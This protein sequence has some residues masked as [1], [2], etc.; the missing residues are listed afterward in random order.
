L[1]AHF[2]AQGATHWRA[3]PTPYRDVTSPAVADFA[4]E[5]RAE[6]DFH[7]F[8]QFLSGKSAAAAQGAARHAGMKIGMISDIATGVDPS[9]SDCWGAPDDVLPG[10]SIGAPPDY[11]NAE[12]QGWG[13]TALSPR[14]LR[15]RGFD[16]FTAML[17]A[18]MAHAG[19]VRIDHVMSMM[20]LWVIPD[21]AKPLEGAYLRYPVEDLFRLTLLESYLH[22]AIVIGE[23][24][25]TVPHGFRDVLS[26][27]GLAGMQVLWFEREGG[28]F[29]PRAR[30]RRES[31][32]MTTTHDLPTLA[33]WWRGTDIGWRSQ[34][35]KNFD[36]E[37]ETR[38][39]ENDRRTL[40]WTM[41]DAGCA[42]GEPPAPDDAEPALQAALRYVGSA[43]SRLAV[44][45]IEDVLALP[46]QPNLPSTIDEH[47]NWRRR[48]PPGPAFSSEAN[49]RAEIFVSARRHP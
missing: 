44:C 43:P 4:R 9:G 11:F 15:E 32:A 35:F 2:R 13:V 40:W 37:A 17:R 48:L 21:G 12:G 38:G 45:A 6:V 16:L 30:W 39:R 8:L 20:R 19:G 14:A 10:L 23:D 33:G 29:I 41:V 31:L 34:V 28:G 27:R 24:L 26:Y 22:R 46:E 42:S 49:K 47:P 5:R 7:L 25:G 36:T 1:D 3:W 18:N